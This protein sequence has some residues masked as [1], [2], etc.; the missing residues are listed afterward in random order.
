MNILCTPLYE[1]QL[2]EILEK[3]ALEDFS[4]TKKFKLYLD[5]ILINIPT[6][7]DKYKPSIYLD[8]KNVKDIEH[9]NFTIVFNREKNEET[10][11]I[12]AIF[13]KE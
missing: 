7:V 8:D 3:F 5:T 4:A 12:L 2:K 13:E 10:Y 1:R 6:K 9:E 11:L